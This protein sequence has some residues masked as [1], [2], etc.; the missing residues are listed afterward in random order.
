MIG[1]DLGLASVGVA[2]PSFFGPVSRRGLPWMVALLHTNAFVSRAYLINYADLQNFHEL[3]NNAAVSLE[4]YLQIMFF[5]LYCNRNCDIMRRAGKE[6][7]HAD[8]L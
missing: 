2:A 4:H 1:L 6:A 5:R 8:K 3:H 7:D